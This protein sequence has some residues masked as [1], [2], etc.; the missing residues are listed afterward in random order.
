MVPIKEAIE[1]RAVDAMVDVL[2]GR[3]D[4]LSFRE[5]ARACLELAQAETLNE[6]RTILMG[7]AIG[8]LKFAHDGPQPLAKLSTPMT[9]EEDDYYTLPLPCDHERGPVARSCASAIVRPTH[10]VHPMRNRRC[11]RPAELARSSRRGRR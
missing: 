2:D 1:A 11:R 3:A 7:M 9:V 8:W 6:V 10:G 5:E 4:V